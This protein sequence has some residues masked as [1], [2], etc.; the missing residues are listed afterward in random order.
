MNNIIE[1]KHLS[2]QFGEVKAVQDLSFRVKEGELFAFL[3]LN[4]AG[5]STTISIMCGQL[6]KTAGK[7]IIDGADIDL[8]PDQIKRELGVVFQNSVLDKDLSVLD[9][10]ES[11]AALYGITGSTFKARISELSNLLDL[12][13]LL[14]RPVGKLSGGQRRR[15]DI[16]RAILHKPKILILD[17]PTTGLDPQTRKTLWNVMT[18]LRLEQNLTI[19]LTTH[20]MEEA[21]DADY[22]IILDN[23]KIT[24]EGTPLQLKN[25]Y[26][27]DYITLYGV[28]EQQVK[29]LDQPYE[30]VKDAFRVTVPNTSAATTLILKHPEI[31]I[32]YEITKGKMDDVFLAVTG[33][34]LQGGA[35]K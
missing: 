18:K 33:K 9:N 2:K 24:A 10:L 32:D 5:K 34:T 1:I 8:N 35:E 13:D 16:A 11:R 25:S 15:I 26:T 22:V 21:A 14:K 4:G 20:Y 19:F 28:N 6:K 23:G 17:E 3:G 30:P 29:I 31:F 27:R 12:E 7:V